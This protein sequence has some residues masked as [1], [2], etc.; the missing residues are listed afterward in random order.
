VAAT[1]AYFVLLSPPLPGL[2]V[3]FVDEAGLLLLAVLAVEAGD[4]V[5]PPARCGVGDSST[6]M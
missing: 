3:L 2:V 1:D 5:A 6:R 4:T